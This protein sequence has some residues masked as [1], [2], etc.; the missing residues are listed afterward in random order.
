M[1]EVKRKAKYQIETRTV[2]TDISTGEVINDVT[3][4]GR[5]STN[6]KGWVIVY[7]EKVLEL[8]TKCPTFATFKVFTYLSMGQQFE[9]K[10]MITTKAAV[11]KELGITK[12]TC[13][14]AFKWLKENFIV[15]E[16][17]IN[18]HKEFMVNP[19]YVTVGRD[20]KAR[21]KEWIRRWDVSGVPSVRRRRRSSDKSESTAG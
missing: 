14:A 11:Q 19:N 7:T 9:E 6:G 1:S 8:L 5:K 21:M 15:N 16:C 20:K 10:G 12:P 17:K 3:R 4:L 18:G 2:V 13:L